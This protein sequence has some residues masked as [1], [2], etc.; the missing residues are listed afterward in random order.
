MILIVC[1]ASMD[2]LDRV[3][4]I[5]DQVVLVCVL[6][7]VVTPRMCPGEARFVHID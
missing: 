2:A 7:I 3:I 6:F 4:N 1:L 5:K